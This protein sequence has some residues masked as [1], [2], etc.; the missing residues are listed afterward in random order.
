MS[1][2]AVSTLAWVWLDTTVNLGMSLQIMLADEAFLAVRA[3]E[4]SI[5]E[6]GLDM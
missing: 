1:G 3:L 6:M 2:E 4:L 5:S